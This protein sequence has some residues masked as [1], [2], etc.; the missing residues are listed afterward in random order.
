MTRSARGKFFHHP[1]ATELEGPDVVPLAYAVPLSR[2]ACVAITATFIKH[3][4][5]A[6]QQ[7]PM[8]VC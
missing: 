8:Y 1:C 6:R 4:L 3:I 2:E 7:V 5:F